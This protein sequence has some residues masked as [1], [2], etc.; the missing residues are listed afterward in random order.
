M[1]FTQK[2]IDRFWS[3]VDKSGTHGSW[4][5]TPCWTWT[6]G[7]QEDGYGCTKIQR[8]N[9]LAH[10]AAYAITY[11]EPQSGMQV[12]HRCDNPPCC[13]PVHLFVGT[14]T[15]NMRDMVSKG[16]H[17]FQRHPELVRHV[18]D[19]RKMNPPIGDNHYLRLYPEKRERLKG[20]K[21]P[22]AK[23]TDAQVNEIRNSS[24][25]TQKELARRYSVCRQLIGQ[26]IRRVIWKHI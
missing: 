18:I 23:L 4:N 24:G 16:R 5:G 10:R 15:D 17:S 21:N 6:F 22:S 1:Q 20:S 13:N 7:T 3:H 2:D 19:T 12:L 8:K 25:I 26:I 11:G 9:L 14:H